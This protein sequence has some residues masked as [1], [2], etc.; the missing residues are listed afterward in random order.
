MS[1]PLVETAPPTSR[2]SDRWW[3]PLTA[4][5]CAAL[6]GIAAYA[7]SLALGGAM[8]VVSAVMIWGW[9]ILLELPAPR[10]TFAALG[11]SAVFVM[12]AVALTREDPLLDWLALAAAGG[13]VVCFLHQLLRRDGRPRLVE[14]LSGEIMAVAL[15]TC[16]AALV[17]LPRTPGGADTVLTLAAAVAA[18]ALVE[19]VPL[20][21]RLFTLPATVAATAAGALAAGL[22]S[23][24]P[25]AFG[26]VVGLAFAI[27]TICVRRLFMS[28][29][30]LA[31]LPAALSLAVAPIMAGG[32]AT[33]VLARLF[34]G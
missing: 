15:L 6:L 14:S 1:E 3:P 20:P 27:T 31:F 10:G 7:G 28:R 18:I 33:Y 11:F 16:G 32:I 19:L 25:V 4:L 30:V 23:H 12:S 24:T 17:G 8:L 9:P 29:P 22:A 13:V 34:V 26:A 2:A 21:E 5:A